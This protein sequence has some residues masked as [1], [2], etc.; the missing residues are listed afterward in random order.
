MVIFV[1]ALNE[2]QPR[3]QWL[4]ELP[5]LLADIKTRPELRLCTTCRTGFVQQVVQEGVRLALFEHPGFSGIEFDACQ[6]FYSYYGIEPPVG[7]LFAPEFSNP[8]FLKLICKTLQ[9]AGR[10]QIPS[11]WTGF[12][13]VFRGLLDV[14]NNEWRVHHGARVDQ[15]VTRSLEALA[16]EMAVRSS[17]SIPIPDAMHLIHSLG[18][19]GGEMIEQLLSDE[20]IMRL[21]GTGMTGPLSGPPD[22]IG[23]AYERLG[24]HLQ[25]QA[26]FA[27]CGA[28]EPVPEAMLDI[29]TAEPGYAEALAIQLPERNGEELLDVIHDEQ[30]RSNVLIPWLYA[31]EWRDLT[32][33]GI[34]A[35]ALLL[36]RLG[37]PGTFERAIDAALVLAMR[38]NG[39]LDSSWLQKRLTRLSMAERDPIWCRYLYNAWERGTTSPVRR[40]VAAAWNAPTN[41]EPS[42]HL[43]WLRV[44]CWFFAAADRRIRDCATRAAIKIGQL[45]PGA[46]VQLCTELLH[47]DDD[48]IVER[49][50]AASYGTHLRTRNDEALRL[51]ANEVTPVFDDQIRANGLIR[52]HARCIC[53]LAAKR[54]LSI[55][56]ETSSIRARLRSE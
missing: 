8:L 27:Q 52:D 5:V 48:Y 50:L 28:N 13:T 4:F 6:S 38:P 17:R 47:V 32:T 39:P 46:W 55:K 2:S 31:L 41:L 12:R 45:N 22:E 49:V 3:Q 15:A 24:D 21:P 44:L 14:R 29:A 56:P 34:R 18:L 37:D 25:V 51:L 54:G 1:D 36:E 7:P 23:F 40:I 11:G 10:Q 43:A 9:D 33:I 53:D 30:K 35:E 20:L 16:A 42:L 26:G 19:S